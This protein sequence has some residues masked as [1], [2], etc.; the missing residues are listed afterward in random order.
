MMTLDEFEDRMLA[1]CEGDWIDVPTGKAIL[2]G[3]F[4][5]GFSAGEAEAALAHLQ[6]EGLIER[7]P[8]QSALTDVD[9][10]PDSDVDKTEIRATTL[11]E[12]Y[13]ANTGGGAAP[14][15]SRSN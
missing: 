2:E 4:A 10:I 6:A 11:G 13:L 14:A 12:D 5:C 9:C 7:R 1:M 15:I 3:W 8:I